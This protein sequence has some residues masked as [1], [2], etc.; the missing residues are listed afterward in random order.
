MGPTLAPVSRSLVELLRNRPGRG[1]SPAVCGALFTM[2]T[3]TLT[4]GVAF[5]FVHWGSA[6][7]WPF[8]YSAMLFAVSIGGSCSWWWINTLVEGRILFSVAH[9]R[10]VTVADLL[11][12][13][14]M[15]LAAL[16]LVAS[17]WPGLH[18]LL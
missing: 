12:V 9:S 11:V 7:R 6:W 18:R 5:A 8:L 16:L 15:L 3:A 2:F 4:A 13:P 17:G 1:V 14:A 10:G